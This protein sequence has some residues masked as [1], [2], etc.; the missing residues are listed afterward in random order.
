MH[1]VVNFAKIDP[2]LK[3]DSNQAETYA[4]QWVQSTLTWVY[5]SN[6]VKNRTKPQ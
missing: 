5:T 1:L 6:R 3:W 2:L 4:V